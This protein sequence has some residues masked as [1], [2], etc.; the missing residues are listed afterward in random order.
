MP[1]IGVLME[2]SLQEPGLKDAFL[3]LLAR[4]A[5]AAVGKRDVSSGI[6]D[7]KTAF[8]SW[9]NC[10]K[11]SFCKWPVIAVIII[12]GLIILSIVWCI[13]RCCCC[14]LSCCCKCCYCLKCCGNC[15][16]CCDPP[17]GKGHKYLD[18]PYIPP[19]HDQGQGYRPQAPMTPGFS[20]KST[21]PQYA[22]FDSSADK[23]DADS[24][25]AMP[26]WEEANSKKVLIEEE[27]V[28]LE[29]MKKPES[30]QNS[31]LNVST[32]AQP[33]I[34]TTVSPISRSPNRSPYGQPVGQAGP[35]GYM[36]ATRAE[37]D[38]YAQGFNS[39]DTSAY[40]Q[41]S[42][43]NSNQSYGNQGYES[44]SYGN[45]GYGAQGYGNQG[46]G[47]QGYG[48]AAGA[49][50][51]MGRQTPQQ[52]YNDGYRGT[53]P[54]GYPQSRT[55]R[56]YDE[57]GRS[58]TPGSSRARPP[59]PLNN[60]G[61]GNPTRMGSPGPQ[62]GGYGYGNPSR[63]RSPAPQ[64]GFEYPPRSQTQT[65]NSYNNR[66]YSPAPSRQYSSDSTRPLA[67]ARGPPERQYSSDSTRPLAAAAAARGPPE[68]QYSSGSPRPQAAQPPPVHQYAQRQYSEPSPSERTPP[69]SPLKNT[70]GFDFNSGFSRPGS[71][72]SSPPAPAQNTTATTTANGGTAYPGYR[73][74]KPQGES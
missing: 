1:H 57:Y 11:F 36:P 32:A 33:T 29:P 64:V 2:R 61:Y 27:S 62:A 38:P 20:A 56:P 70:G 50:G 6:S 16:G 41:A 13:V 18:E 45:Q 25:P 35:N 55:P 21:A 48:A 17:R 4:S 54:Q 14:G 52:G 15:M 53:A 59:P 37:T 73:A 22:E 69:V 26:S 34:P 51:A 46:Y 74:Y 39:Y 43:D 10:M 24:L 7:A 5:I 12:G 49:V 65:P 66:T 19:H 28:E 58:G 42:H 67:G 63:M 3:N 68:R 60:T 23:K 8:S 72:P 9:D 30:T 47:S 71:S 40:G 44:N 31:S